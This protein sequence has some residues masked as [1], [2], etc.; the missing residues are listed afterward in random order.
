MDYKNIINKSNKY[1]Y[2]LI[3]GKKAGVL[4][5]SNSKRKAL[6]EAIEVIEKKNG[7]LEGKLVAKLKLVEISK[8]DQEDNKRSKIKTIGGPIEIK[9][10]FYRIKGNDLEKIE[11]Y[12]KN[13]SLFLTD[14]FLKKKE[15][16]SDFTKY[17]AS[18]AYNDKLYT[19]LFVLNIV[20][21]LIKIE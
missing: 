20:D 14:N 6:E 5:S 3:I 4:G 12:E 16:N 10:E 11:G 2:I 18:A 9:I 19:D 15:I 13:N 8:E 17:V 21:R 1:H 7:K